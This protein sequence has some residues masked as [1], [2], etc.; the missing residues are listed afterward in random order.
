MELTLDE[1]K[2]IL[3]YIIQN[4]EKLQENGKMPV[5]CCLEAIAGIGKSETIETIAKEL[6][7]NYVKLSLSMVS[8]QGDLFGFPVRLHYVCKDDKCTW[9]SPELIDAYVKAGWTITDET[10]MSYALPEWFKNID[11]NKGTIVNLDDYSRCM[12]HIMQSIMELIY[13]QE[14]WSFTLPPRTTILLSSNPENGDYNTSSSLDEAQKTR[15]ITFNV[16]FDIH[17]WANYLLLN[18]ILYLCIINN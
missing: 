9:I 5:A 14:T 10:K 4:N 3:K 2:P 15:L 16:K 1:I 6:D 18:F 11:V 12:P 13:K 17:S 7:Y 8:E